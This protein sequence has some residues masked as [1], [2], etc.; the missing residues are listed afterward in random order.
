MADRAPIRGTGA[1]PVLMRP[2]PHRRSAPA[3]ERAHAGFSLTELLVVLAVIV[4]VIGV[5]IPAVNL[6][7]G[8][9]SIES[10]QNQIASVL[11]LARGR[12]LAL[13]RETGL[14]FYIDPSSDRFAMRIVE[15]VH[16]G[17]MVI[18]LVPDMDMHLLPAGVAMQFP[19]GGTT[20]GARSTPGYV[21]FNP[22]GNN[23]IPVGGAILFDRQGRLLVTNYALA[24]GT[25]LG[26]MLDLSADG[27]ISHLGVVLFHR[28]DF[29][30]RFTFE[31]PSGYPQVEREEESWLDENGHLLLIN[32]YSGTFV[33]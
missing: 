7:S 1:L 18:D 15:V 27:S 25:E 12:A 3:M 28:G 26:R 9:Q 19:V 14:F 30:S 13:Q 4:L 21:G 24:S 22:V 33:E 29:T 16:R 8:R 23:N 6:L 32:R 11:S 5:A 20:G 17:G 10:A 31:D 2:A